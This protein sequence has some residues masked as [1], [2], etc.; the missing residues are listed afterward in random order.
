MHFR[1]LPLITAFILMLGSTFDFALADVFSID[2]PEV[3]KGEQEIEV[4]GAVRTA[5][6]SMPTLCAIVWRSNTLMA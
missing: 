4:N 3:V 5:F 6:R 1:H 2:E